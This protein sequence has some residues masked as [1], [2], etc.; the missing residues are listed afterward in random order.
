MKRSLFILAGL[1]VTSACTINLY[2][3]PSNDVEPVKVRKF[4]SPT[5]QRNWINWYPYPMGYPYMDSWYYYNPRILP[6]G[7]III[8]ARPQNPQGP[9]R[10]RPDARPDVRPDRPMPRPDRPTR[11]DVRP[12]RPMP[13]PNG[14]A[15]PRGGEETPTPKPTPDR[16]IIR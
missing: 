11:P 3:M 7:P 2:E 4:T 9:M 13:R 6:R 16:G 10:P 8:N 14:P 1:L 12:D 5:V 15:R